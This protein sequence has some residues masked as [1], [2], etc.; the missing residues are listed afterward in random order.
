MAE[1][2]IPY[3]FD[4]PFDKTDYITRK[5]ELGG[6]ECLGYDEESQRIRLSTEQAKCVKFTMKYAPEQGYG[7][8]DPEVVTLARFDYNAVAYFDKHSD[9]E[10]STSDA[11]KRELALKVSSKVTERYK[12]FQDYDPFFADLGITG[13]RRAR[14]SGRGMQ[15][16][17]SGE[18]VP[19]ANSQSG[20]AIPLSPAPRL[21]QYKYI[22]I[23]VYFSIQKLQV[24]GDALLLSFARTSG[25]VLYLTGQTALLG[26][27][28]YKQGQEMFTQ[29]VKRWPKKILSHFWHAQSI[30]A[31]LHQ[32]FCTFPCLCGRSVCHVQPPSRRVGSGTSFQH[33]P[34]VYRP[35]FLAIWR[36]RSLVKTVFIGGVG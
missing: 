33:R 5:T 29:Q 28:C 13:R 27:K 9:N 6:V 4:F 18:L 16:L 20:V 22:A 2:N 17:P 32:R 24:L 21:L 3:T 12:F 36:P 19:F 23:S 25:C 35:K 7:K 30:S 10:E 1:E 11:E 8:D 34:L 26:I 15:V 14:H 31:L